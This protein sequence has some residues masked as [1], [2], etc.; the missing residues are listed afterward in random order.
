MV[1]VQD[2]FTPWRCS[3]NEK[4]IGL[5]LNLLELWRRQ[6]NIDMTIRM[7]HDDRTSECYKFTESL[8]LVTDNRWS[9]KLNSTWTFHS[10]ELKYILVFINNKWTTK[11]SQ[12][13]Y[14]LEGFYYRIELI[15][16]KVK[17]MT[18]CIRIIFWIMTYYNIYVYKLDN[19][20]SST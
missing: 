6:S 3:T 13:W 1:K 20:G 10:G 2:L 5:G 7:G 4:E 19:M 8:Q 14:V 9:E 12:Y 16:I 15:I 17:K 18:N 11:Y